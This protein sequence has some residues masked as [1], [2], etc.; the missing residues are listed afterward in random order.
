MT[1]ATAKRSVTRST[2]GSAS[3]ASTTADLDRASAESVASLLLDLHRRQNSILIVV[4]HSTEL[5]SKFPI[6]FELVD[7][8]GFELGPDVRGLELGPDGR[9]LDLLPAGGAGGGGSAARR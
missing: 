9:G 1:P 8:R 7:G 6:R 4:T 3:A 2:S 5:A